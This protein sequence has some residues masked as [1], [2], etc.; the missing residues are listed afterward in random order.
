MG[1][2]GDWKG[3]V[4]L[5]FESFRGLL[6]ETISTLNIDQASK[7]VEPFVKS[8]ERL[9]VWPREFFL[10]VASRIEFV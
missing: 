6:F 9:S 2:T 5:S 10:D 8:A 3:N 7:E 1:Q 4:P